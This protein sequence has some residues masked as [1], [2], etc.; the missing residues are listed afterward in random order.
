MQS[1]SSIVLISSLHLTACTG[2]ELA[3]TSLPG[4]GNKQFSHAPSEILVENRL[5]STRVAGRRQFFS[6]IAR[7]ALCTIK[8]LWAK[9]WF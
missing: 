8:K 5:T 3:Y 9:M 4:S 1:D 6:S 7:P 2:S